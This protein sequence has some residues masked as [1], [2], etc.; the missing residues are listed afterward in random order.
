MF[1][2]ISKS[3]S[4][5]LLSSVLLASCADK[6]KEAASALYKEGEAAVAAHNYAGALAVLD[7]LNA[8]YP[9]QFDIRKAALRVRAQAMEG[10]AIDSIAAG[11]QALAQATVN[12]DAIKPSFRHVD[13][14]VG[15]EGYYLPVG[16]SEKVMMANT[17]QARVSDKGYFYIVAN[18]QGRAIGL[19]AIEFCA[20]SEAVTSS[21]ISPSRIVK[22]EGSESASFNPEDLVGVGQWLV[23][24]PSADKIVLIGSKGKVNVKMDKKL[25][26]EIVDCYRFSEALQAHRTASIKREKFERMLATARGQ[27]A[28]LPAPETENKD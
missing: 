22:V 10:M 8:R 18:V 26:N 17:V 12:L 7:T 24:H 11:D 19:N 20:G 13:S 9:K 27:I 23:D 14:S 2:A 21:A 5:V 4:A 1:N 25:R 28:N 15:L 16:V 3:I 6:D